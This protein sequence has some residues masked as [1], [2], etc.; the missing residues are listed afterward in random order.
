MK[1]KE[2]LLVPEGAELEQIGDTVSYST[3]GRTVEFPTTVFRGRPFND[4]M[5]GLI[6][7]KRSTI[8]SS[9][10][11]GGFPFNMAGFEGK[12]GKPSWEADIWAAGRRLFVGA[13]GFVNHCVELIYKDGSVFVFGA[14]SHGMYMESFDIATGKC[15]FRFCTCYWF[16]FSEKWELK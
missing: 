15:K 9:S 13:G 5:L 6:E 4:I 3:G 11:L 12:G 1:S 16:N 14:E 2:G 7:E 8:I 10:N